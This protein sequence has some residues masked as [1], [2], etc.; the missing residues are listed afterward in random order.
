MQMS[1]VVA[2]IDHQGRA[3]V[4]TRETAMKTIH[5][6][7][8][9]RAALCVMPDEFFGP[10][11]QVEGPAGIVPLPEAMDGLVELYRSVAGEHRD[12]REFRS[13]MEAERR[14]LL[15][16]TIERAGPDRSG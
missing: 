10:W 8:R 16:I 14:V 11:V 6:R 15:T 13:A 5:V 1:P 3:V 12:W 7:R 4:S 9:P 2:G